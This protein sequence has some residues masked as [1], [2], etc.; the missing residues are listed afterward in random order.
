MGCEQLKIARTFLGS[1][2]P[3]LQFHAWWHIGVGVG[4]VSILFLLRSY[5]PLPVVHLGFKGVLFADS[6]PQ[7]L[8]V[9]VPR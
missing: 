3:L 6:R 2:S 4:S 7:D 5:S 1:F 8:P 9:P